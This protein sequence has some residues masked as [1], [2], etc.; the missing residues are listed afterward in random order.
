[1]SGFRMLMFAGEPL[2]LG[3]PDIHSEEYIYNLQHSRLHRLPEELQLIIGGYLPQ[4][5]VLALRA[6][7]RDFHHIHVQPYSISSDEQEL[8][9]EVLRRDDYRRNCQLDREG[10]LPNK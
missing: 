7:A 2:C 4:H 1:M 6:T 9:R 3:L 8:F 5:A 10:K